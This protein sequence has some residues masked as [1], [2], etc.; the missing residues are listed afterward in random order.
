MYQ[1]EAIMYTLEEQTAGLTL[2]TLPRGIEERDHTSDHSPW[3]RQYLD[4]YQVGDPAL[5]LD[6]FPTLPRYFPARPTDG[7]PS[8]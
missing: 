1:Q 8:Y 5:S 3:V 2:M 4:W 7:A 6:P